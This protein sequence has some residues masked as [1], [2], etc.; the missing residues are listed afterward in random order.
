MDKILTISIAAYNAEKWLDRCLKSFISN[1]IL[2]KAEIIIVNDGSCD[3]TVNIANEYVKMFPDTFILIDK[4]NGGHG[5]TINASVKKA[6]GKYYK[7]VDADDWVKTDNL[8][9]LIQK[10]EKIDVDMVFTTGYEYYSKD[11]TKKKVYYNKKDQPYEDILVNKVLDLNAIVDYIDISMHAITYKTEI[12]KKSKYKIDEKCFYVD[13][14][15][16]LFYL[17]NVDKI[18][19]LNLPVYVYFVGREDQSINIDKRLAQ[20]NQYLRVI[21]NL[22]CFLDLEFN[23]LS[24]P[25]KK[26][27]KQT[28]ITLVYIEYKLLMMIQDTNQACSEI[29]EFDKYLKN[30]NLN[31]YNEIVINYDSKLMKMITLLRKYNFHGLNVIHILVKRRLYKKGI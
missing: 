6:S 9:K 2:N 10:L 11:N 21:K 26:I 16:D 29:R 28:I 20:R 24:N 4:E 13:M 3:N 1:E 7:V 18:M 12:L 22:M 5:S 15:Y 17:L 8:I 23:N 30:S 19:L 25:A 27:V 14:E 31:I